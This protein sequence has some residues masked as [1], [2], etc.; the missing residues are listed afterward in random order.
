MMLTV[1]HPRN[2]RSNVTKLSESRVLR[3][4]LAERLRRSTVCDL[5]SCRCALNL[6]K[7]IVHLQTELSH[8][9]EKFLNLVK[10]ID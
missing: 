9:L 5:A 8:F 6:L 7:R 2:T 3:S 10:R 4:E 1:S